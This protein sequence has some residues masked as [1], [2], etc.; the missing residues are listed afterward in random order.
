LPNSKQRD[1]LP[2]FE[3]HFTHFRRLKYFELLA[4]RAVNLRNVGNFTPEE[5]PKTTVLNLIIAVIALD[6]K[7]K[8]RLLACEIKLSFRK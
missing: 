2:P 3:S 4:N 1:K 7:R 5:Q 8:D 6:L